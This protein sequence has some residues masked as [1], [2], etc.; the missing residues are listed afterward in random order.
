MPINS[1]GSLVQSV[2]CKLGLEYWVV[3]CGM[4]WIGMCARVNGVLGKFSDIT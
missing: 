3:P 4:T 1:S 2:S